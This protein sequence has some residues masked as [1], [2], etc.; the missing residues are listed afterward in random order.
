MPDLTQK[1]YIGDGVHASFDGYN[2]RLSTQR[3]DGEHVIYLEPAVFAALVDYQKGI[4]ER[5]TTARE[6]KE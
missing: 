1:T 2:I 4:V 6:K 5:L 3:S